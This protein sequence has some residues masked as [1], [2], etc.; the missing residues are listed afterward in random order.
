MST[1]GRWLGLTNTSLWASV[2]RS[3]C[4]YEL[5][6]FSF[7]LEPFYILVRDPC[8]PALEHDRKT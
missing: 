2:T 7:E 4:T 6:S 1:F 3:F 5:Q 8:P